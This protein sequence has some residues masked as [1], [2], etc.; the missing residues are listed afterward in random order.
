MLIWLKGILKCLKWF[1]GPSYLQRALNSLLIEGTSA[2]NNQDKW[3]RSQQMSQMLPYCYLNLPIAVRTIQC[4]DMFVPTLLS[5][6]LWTN[7]IVSQIQALPHPTT[8]IKE[9]NDGFCYSQGR[10]IEPGDHIFIPKKCS[11]L[12]CTRNGQRA[13]LL[14]ES[15]YDQTDCCEFQDKLVQPGWQ[16]S[17]PFSQGNITCYNGSLVD[18]SN[19]KQCSKVAL[20]QICREQK[21]SHRSD[22]HELLKIQKHLFYQNDDHFSYPRWGPVPKYSSAITLLVP[23]THSGKSLEN[24]LETLIQPME[25]FP[26]TTIAYNENNAWY[27]DS[28]LLVK[29]KRTQSNAHQYGSPGMSNFQRVG[30]ISTERH[31]DEAVSSVL[32]IYHAQSRDHV[33]IFDQTH[34]VIYLLRFIIC[35]ISGDWS[36]I[37]RKI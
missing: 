26:T 25:Q 32:N 35:N 22:L 6:S 16:I 17:S 23:N 4:S 36:Y 21:C 20:D 3:Q 13:K 27:L 12:I 14:F 18:M 2:I 29:S 37:G 11:K 1:I 9:K 24:F 5:V 30:K 8:L 15:V 7:F 19:L 31:L 10:W 33:S 28:E 34:P